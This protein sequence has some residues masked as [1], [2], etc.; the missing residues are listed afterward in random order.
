MTTKEDSSDL[1]FCAEADKENKRVE[2]KLSST[3]MTDTALYYCTLSPTVTG[4]SYQHSAQTDST[5][6]WHRVTQLRSG[7][8][9]GFT[10]GSVLE[11]IAIQ[12][13][14]LEI[15]CFRPAMCLI[16]SWN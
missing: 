5:W 10:D 9:R 8:N 1:R 16:V 14:W 11:P 15:Y 3:K 13:T 2:L 6:E 4:I 12:S 7:L